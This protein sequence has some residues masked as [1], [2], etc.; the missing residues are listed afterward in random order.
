MTTSRLPIVT[1]PVVAS[2]LLVACAGNV[3]TRPEAATATPTVAVAE[4]SVPPT[5]VQ[6]TAALPGFTPQASQRN[7]AGIPLPYAPGAVNIIVTYTPAPAGGTLVKSGFTVVT[8]G[9]NYFYPED[10]T[11]TSGTTVEWSYDV[12][13]GETES[14][15]NVVA[16]DKTFVSGDLNPGTHYSFTFQQSG[17]YMYVCSYHVKQMTAKVTVQ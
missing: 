6:P 16:L 11:V 8:V 7:A 10:L 9:D 15:H 1:V 17:Q 12:G 5:V 3:G 13:S 2:W 14:T 4:R